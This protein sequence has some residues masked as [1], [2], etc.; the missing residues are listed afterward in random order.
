MIVFTN[1][2]GEKVYIGTSKPFILQLFD[3]STGVI[4]QTQKAPFQDGQT[5]IDSLL[6]PRSISATV[7]IVTNT[8]EEVFEKR[9]FLSRVFNPKLGPGTLRYEYPGGARE[10]RAVADTPPIFPS[11]KENK[12]TGYQR[13]LVN[14]LCPDPLWFDPSVELLTMAS[15]IGGMSFPM[16][17]PLSL[18]TVGQT[19]FVE[20]KGDIK[21]PIF[22]TFK[23]PL[24]NP[25]LENKTTGETLKISQTIPVGERLEINTA[26]GQKSVRRIDSSGNSTNAF[27]WVSPDSVLWQLVPGENELS[28][29]ATE[30][31]SDSAVTVTFYHRFVEV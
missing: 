17:F 26:F 24:K 4:I 10:V 28:Y 16:S 8:D 7:A 6:E 9:Q 14:L 22:L 18:G 3:T 19:L 30:E 15:F 11:G 20:N 25:I 29:K 21:T 1:A 13:A 31:A 2:R 12:S 27:H 23:G 5:Y